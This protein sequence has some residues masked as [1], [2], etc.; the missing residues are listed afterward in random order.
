MPLALF[1]IVFLTT[2]EEED[3]SKKIIVYGKTFSKLFDLEVAKKL[4]EKGYKN[5]R[6]LEG[7]LSDWEK[8]GYPVEP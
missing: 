8:K 4:A 6:I 7:T 3:K 1:D 2:F 5:T